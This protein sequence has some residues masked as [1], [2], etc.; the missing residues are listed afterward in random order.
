MAIEDGPS[1]DP[2]DLINGYFGYISGRF[3]WQIKV[4]DMT[5][6]C[7]E[8]VLIMRNQLETDQKLVPLPF[9]ESRI[10]LNMKVWDGEGNKLIILPSAEAIELHMEVFRL[11]LGFLETKALP[12]I[13]QELIDTTNRFTEDIPSGFIRRIQG[14]QEQADDF[15]RFIDE[16]SDEIDDDPKLREDH[17]AIASLILAEYISLAVGGLYRPWVILPRPL[18]FEDRILMKYYVE[19]WGYGAKEKII[20]AIFGQTKSKFPLPLGAGVATHVRINP[21]DGVI[22]KPLG[23]RLAEKQMIAQI[24]EAG[25]NPIDLEAKRDQAQFYMNRDIIMKIWKETKN[26]V[27]PP[28]L[29]FSAYI[30]QTASTRMITSMLFLL[31][32]VIPFVL[33]EYGNLADHARMVTEPRTFVAQSGKGILDPGEFLRASMVSVAL[34]LALVANGWH[35]VTVRDFAVTQFVIYL[36]ILILWLVASTTY[37]LFFYTA[38]LL[39]VGFFFLNAWSGFGSLRKIPK[40]FRPGRESLNNPTS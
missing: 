27:D 18:K 40:E 20:N 19:S 23:A 7:E 5:S 8:Q 1:L 31:S 26:S 3:D 21:P 30:D 38:I 10:Q 39:S 24:E 29:E 34:A 6:S 11:S 25:A 15:F 9:R 17:A 12:G 16:L 4:M 32:L 2:K 28:L 37:A 14:E 13:L 22:F 35:S 33:L 36:A